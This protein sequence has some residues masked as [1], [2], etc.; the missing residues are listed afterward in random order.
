MS[1]VE[2]VFSGVGVAVPI[3]LLGWWI[4]RWRGGD[5]APR[6]RQRGADGSFNVQAGG[7]V[8]FDREH[9]GE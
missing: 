8:R 7:D 1:W 4:T 5:S 9:K 3:A 2:W 6:Q